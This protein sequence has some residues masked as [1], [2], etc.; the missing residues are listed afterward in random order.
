MSDARPEPIGPRPLARAETEARMERLERFAN[1]LDARFQVLGFRFGWDSVLGLV[2]GV[3]DAA[4]A[5]AGAW[6]VTEGARLGASRGVL[7][8][9]AA[10]SG[11]DFMLGSVP[12]IGDLFDV[13]FKAN[14]RNIAL[15]RRDMA[16]QGR[17]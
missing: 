12:L 5:A 2:P 14:R 10:N 6:I 16:R 1:Q 7:V 9:M 15:L 13:V 17:A 3:G 11:V 4:T 8:R